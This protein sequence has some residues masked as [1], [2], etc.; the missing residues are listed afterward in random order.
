MEKREIDFK[1]KYDL[2][3]SYSVSIAKMKEDL[4]ELEK[5]GATHIDIEIDYCYDDT[6]ISIESISRRIETDEE[7]KK[8]CD[9]NNSR[10]TLNRNR[11]LE[12]LRILQLKYKDVNP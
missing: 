5:L 9:E 11:E 3:W 4:Y 1:I 7:F 10:I 6:F 2:D 8:R 12:Q